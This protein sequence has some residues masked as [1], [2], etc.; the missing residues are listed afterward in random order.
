MPMRKLIGCAA[1]LLPALAPA[2][3]A[4]WVIHHFGVDFHGGDEWDPEVGGL[5]IKAFNHQLT[6]GDLVSFHNEH[7]LLIPRL[8]YLLLNVFTKWNNLAELY[9]AWVIF[10]ATSIGVLWLMHKTDDEASRLPRPSV[11]GR[12]TVCVMLLFDPAQRE[13]WQSGWGLANALPGALT[14]AAIAVATGAG[15]SWIKLS[16]CILL[17]AGATYSNG[18]GFLAWILAGIVLAWSDSRAEFWAKGAK[19]AVWVAAAAIFAAIYFYHYQPPPRLNPFHPSL[20][21]KLNFI[22]IYTGNPFMFTTTTWTQIDCAPIGVVVLLLLAVCGVYFVAC[23]WSRRMEECGR[24]IVWLAVGGFG[25]GT[26]I[27]GAI[28]RSGYGAEQGVISRYSSFAVFMPVAIVNLAPLVCRDLQR[29]FS[30]AGIWK[31]A[32]WDLCPSFLAGA[33]VAA[34]LVGLP[35]A[36]D[37]I[38]VSQTASL[39]GKGS[40]LLLDVAP[41]NPNLATLVH[42]NVAELKEEAHAMN[43]MGYL[44]PP[45]ITGNDAAAIQDGNTNPDEVDGRIDGE[46]PGETGSLII[47]GWA[48]L[49]DRRRC[50]DQVFL[51]YQDAG[52]H[53][54]IFA[55]ATMGL[56]RADVAL[57]RPDK[58]RR[59]QYCGWAANVAASD[60]PA[61]LQSTILKAWVLD[62]ET[63][64]AWPLPNGLP[65]HK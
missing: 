24:A 9:G 26:A 34:I 62:T 39:T 17:A 12:W 23:W 18:C 10:F 49:P 20:L 46:R 53:S 45:L 33:I 19:L 64:K 58:D 11:I 41:N 56:E 63:G 44:H 15:R 29:R 13:N 25:L 60:M 36:M 7:R 21:S 54:I 16:L 2:A 55:V 38:R 48:I 59:F 5:Y 51:T 27:L 4:L 8:L 22:A 50:A 35:R 14:I 30:H 61:D 52:D 1:L 6:F 28:A 47:S 32:R 57:N 42:A 43:D 40:L 31:S 3:F 37:N 65:V